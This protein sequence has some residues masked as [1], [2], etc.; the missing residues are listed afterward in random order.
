MYPVASMRKVSHTVR[1]REEKATVDLRVRS[2][3]MKVKMNQPCCV[4]IGE[5]VE[6]DEKGD[7]RRGRTLLRCKMRLLLPHM[8]RL[9]QTRL[10]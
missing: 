8:Q 4:K 5:C 2:Q 3:R 7:I 6:R 1:K 9:S 10:E